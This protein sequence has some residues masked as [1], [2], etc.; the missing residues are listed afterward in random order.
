VPGYETKLE[1]VSFSRQAEIVLRTLSDR[2]QFSDP[3]G[4]AE[5]LGISSAIWPLFGLLWPSGRILAEHMAS[6]AVLRRSVLEIGCGLGLTSLMMQRAG[7]DITASD[8]HPMAGRFLDANLLLNGLGPLPFHRGDWGTVDATLG[9]FGLIVGSDVLYERSQAS[10]LSAF[11]DRHAEGQAEIII[12]DPNRG[13]R[14]EFRRLMR[15][16]AFEV[17]VVVAPSTTMDGVAYR[18]QI[19]TFRRG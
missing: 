11:I 13:H 5:R 19:L 18:G 4:E 8:I 14:A 12:V 17:E 16:H 7:E 15:A 6:V 3:E 2:Q 1:H 10:D 9:R